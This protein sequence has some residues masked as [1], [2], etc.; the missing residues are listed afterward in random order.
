[1][2][3]L[4]RTSPRP[5]VAGALAALCLLVW[6]AAAQ[7]HPFGPPPRSWLEVDGEVVRL[8]WQ[9]SYDD[10]LAVGEHLGHLEPGTAAA[11]LDPSVRVAP[12]RAEV[13]ALASSAELRTYFTDHIVVE[14]DGRRCEAVAI[15]TDRFLEQGARLAHQCHGPVDEVTLRI[16]ML[17]DINEAYRTY[18][19]AEGGEPGPFAIFTTEQPEHRVDVAAIAG[20][21]SGRA[22]L[23]LL[24][25]VAVLVLALPPVVRRLLRSEPA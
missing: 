22:R 14:Q 3:P 21:G 13:E 20:G 6:P 25:A 9:A 24:G 17:H 15:E 7:A 2:A 11:Y 10:H 8:S 12:A 19:L 18:G 4:P 5:V 23:V 1:M 16:T